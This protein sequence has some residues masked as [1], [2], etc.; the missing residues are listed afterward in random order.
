MMPNKRF[1]VSRR[2]LPL[3]LLGLLLSVLLSG[4]SGPDFSSFTDDLEF[5]DSA[6]KDEIIEVERMAIPKG[7]LGKDIGQAELDKAS[8]WTR[9]KL[10]K[11]MGLVSKPE[12]YLEAN[13]G[14]QCVALNEVE[15]DKPG[16]SRSSWEPG[17]AT[18][19]FVTSCSQKRKL[20][21]LERTLWSMYDT[22]ANRSLDWL[23][24]SR[25]TLTASS[26][27]VRTL[28]NSASP[29]SS[30]WDMKLQPYFNAAQGVLL[31]T[32][33]ISLTVVFIMMVH[34]VQ[35]GDDD[36]RLLS[37]SGWV[38]LGAF[39]GSVAVTITLRLFSRSH[40][41]SPGMA[42]W[43]PNSGTTFFVSD[44]IRMQLDP[45]YIL[46]IVAGVIAAGFKLAVQQEGRELVRFGR[47]MGMAAITSIALAGLVNTLN[48]LFDSWS[49]SLMSSASSMV[50]DAWSRN[51]L[52]ANDFFNLDAPIAVVLVIL[53]WVMSLV[54]KIFAY[55]RAGLLPI[56]VGIAPTWAAMSWSQEGRQAFGKTLGWLVAFLAYKP[57]C[58]LVMATGSAILV[59]SG[60]QDDSMAITLTLTL[61]AI[62]I[63]P[64]LIKLIVPAAQGA[65]G[66]GGAVM[67]AL[68]GGAA[69][70]A[71]A[72]AAALTRGGGG[73][74]QR[75]R[76]HGGEASGGGPATP[77]G[78]K[79]SGTAKAGG[80]ASSTPSVAGSA[81]P[82]TTQSTTQSTTGG[83]V[84]QSGTAPDG[85]S[86]NHSSSGPLP[87][88]SDV[89]AGPDGA[90]MSPDALVP[91]GAKPASAARDID[92][93]ISSADGAPQGANMR[94]RR[95]ERKEF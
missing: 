62:I 47:A 3:A 87:M 39:L 36:G 66:G 94:S 60:A 19:G 38:A 22:Q 11:L 84:D 92:S 25:N 4:C 64:A 40:G 89:V 31:V 37:K 48:G 33:I 59:T 85:V 43:D 70:V 74:I 6:S 72:G 12:D 67:P 90:A 2:L 75:L 23:S 81:S 68:M 5:G 82:S 51:S 53:M 58:A 9:Y 57:V 45:I 80:V 30:K 14:E 49:S 1:M 7:G 79:P 78:A 46:A 17:G 10:N 91:A 63:L 83:G 52:Q 21:W 71:G 55:L 77:D 86:A 35:H 61:S 15:Q 50:S 8:S 69:T 20:T 32:A 42:S 54:M 76:A 95:R 56:L 93:S 44:W 28:K 41:G 65:V 16:D 73:L 26:G 88:S 18:D 34:N 29:D 13:P 27:G 24:T